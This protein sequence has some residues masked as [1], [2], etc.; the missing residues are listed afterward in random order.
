MRR[1]GLVPPVPIAQFPAE[2]EEKVWFFGRRLGGLCVPFVISSGESRRDAVQARQRLG[3]RGARHRVLRPQLAHKRHVAIRR[4][5]RVGRGHPRPVPRLHVREDVE[6]EVHCV[7]G[8]AAAGELA[9]RTRQRQRLVHHDAE[10]VRVRRV[11][12]ADRPEAVVAGAVDARQA[13]HERAVRVRRRHRRTKLDVR[14]EAARVAAVARLE[15]PP[16]RLDRLRDHA[17]AHE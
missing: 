13:R 3:E 8:G 17:R 5:R 2:A 4:G 15:R 14:A 12:D 6:S 7:G 11:P 10:R 1:R 9:E 16:R